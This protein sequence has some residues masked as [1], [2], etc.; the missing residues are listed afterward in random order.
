MLSTFKQVRPFGDSDH[1]GEAA[2][3]RTM[4]VKQRGMLE[5]ME[6]EVEGEDGGVGEGEGEEED[7]DDDEEGEEDVED[8]ATMAE[9][10]MMAERL[11]AGLF[12]Q[13]KTVSAVWRA[14]WRGDA[15]THSYHIIS[16]TTSSLSLAG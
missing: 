9:G 16:I 10:L 3:A 13:S 6:A 12:R 2:T 15:T 7:G 8:K 5:R 1:S 11:L 4:E 14:G